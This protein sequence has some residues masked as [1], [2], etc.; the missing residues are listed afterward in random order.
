M[1]LVRGARLREFDDVVEAACASE[2]AE[3]FSEK[4]AAC[5]PDELAH[6]FPL[7]KMAGI[8]R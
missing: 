8:G 7:G 6:V 1:R 2:P 3:L 5:V 4:L